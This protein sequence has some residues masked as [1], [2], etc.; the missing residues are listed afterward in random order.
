MSNGNS[1]IYDEMPVI[2]GE[3]DGETKCEDVLCSVQFNSL[4]AC[5]KKNLGKHL[6][7]FLVL[8]S[9]SRPRLNSSFLWGNRWIVTLLLKIL[10]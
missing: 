3:T 4:W 8:V 5:L 6:N 9:D 7:T 10:H 2:G 1:S